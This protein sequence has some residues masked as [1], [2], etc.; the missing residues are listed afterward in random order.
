MLDELVNA[1]IVVVPISLFWSLVI[2]GLSKTLLGVGAIILL[3]IL[4]MKTKR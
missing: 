4:V 3:Y 1:G 2:F